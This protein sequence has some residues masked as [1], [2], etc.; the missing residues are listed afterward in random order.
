MSY[1]KKT[2]GGFFWT[3]ALS[4]SIRL[5]AFAKIA[6]LARILLPDQFGEFAVVG[7]VLAF[8]EI[9]TETGINVFLMQEKDS[10][11]KYIDTAWVVSI[12]RGL[13]VSALMLVTSGLVANFFHLPQVR[14]LIIIASIIPVVRGFIN[15]ANVKFQKELNFATDF[16]YRFSIVLVEIG[17]TLLLALNIQASSSLVL[18]LVG[19]AIYEVFASWIFITPRPKAKLNYAQV[20]TVL[21]RG[22][23][24]TG[25]GLFDYV[26]STIDNVVVGRLLGSSALGIYQNAYK[27]SLL[28]G[29]QVNDIYYKTTTPVY[30]KMREELKNLTRAVTLG[31]SGLVAI[32]IVVG[33]AIYILADPL[34]RFILGPNWLA[35]IPAVKVLAILSAVR[36]AAFSF[37]SLFVALQKQKY[38]ALMTLVSMVVMS[39][40]IV[41]WVNRFGLVGAAWA[42][43]VAAAAALPL[44]V[45]FVTKIGRL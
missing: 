26:F 27:L 38:V 18:G 19:S 14:T 43:T 39:I 37:N 32:Q 17:L 28:P 21:G 5:L 9:I 44:T 8:L 35:A 41:P 45:Y 23:W 30:V 25:F 11:A 36:G 3:S 15:P 13:L 34:V 6:V 12:G 24:V 33:F 29:T 2:L 20:K 10:L 7:M 16:W 42:A 40:L 1:F 31:T 4:G 22:K